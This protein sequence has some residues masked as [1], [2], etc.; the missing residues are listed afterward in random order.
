MLVACVLCV[1]LS[2]VV[3][4]LL[5]NCRVWFGVCWL[6]TCCRLWFVDCVFVVCW[7]VVVICCQIA[8]HLLVC[9]LL[10]GCGVFVGPLFLFVFSLQFLVCDWLCVVC[11]LVVRCVVLFVVSCIVVVGCRLL[12]VR[13]VVSGCVL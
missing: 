6:G 13:G 9:C 4:C 3:C 1:G 10:L 8:W 2:C 7:F 12:V 11:L 5:C